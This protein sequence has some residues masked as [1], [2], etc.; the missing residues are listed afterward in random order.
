LE[1]DDALASAARAAS[2]DERVQKVCIWTPDKDLAQCVQSD[3]VV[4]VYRR[5]NTILDAAAVRKKF[6]VEPKFI[7]DFLALVGDSADGYP[8]IDGI[9]PVG[10]ARLINQY[11]AIEDFP[12]AVLGERR[13]L[14]LLF[15]NL[16]TLRTDAELFSDVDELKIGG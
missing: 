12:A 3:R 10:A 7:P 16:A 8:G 13:D 5:T 4:Q 11:G 9:G 6:G 14:A 1:A 15:K 2:A